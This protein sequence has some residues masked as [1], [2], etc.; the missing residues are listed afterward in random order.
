MQMPEYATKNFP[1]VTNDNDLLLGDGYIF[2]GERSGTFDETELE[3]GGCLNGTATYTVSSEKVELSAGSPEMLIRVEPKSIRIELQVNYIEHSL[4]YFDYR[5]GMGVLSTSNGVITTVT[6]EEV[7]LY[8]SYWHRLQGYNLFASPA[9]T[10]ESV[11]GYPVIYQTPRDYMIHSLCGLIKR[12]STGTIANY[13]EVAVSYQ[14]NKPTTE[15]ISLGSHATLGQFPIKFVVPMP[16]Q[17]RMTARLWK[18]V[19]IESGS[20]NFESGNWTE[21]QVTYVAVADRTQNPEALL[22][23]IEKEIEVYY[24][25]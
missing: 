24:T 17:R 20:M 14:W 9:P 18:A 21:N 22:G 6:G 5:Y 11:D 8:G 1:V 12:I 15:T 13:A 16:D 4:K 3:M 25:P 10:V 2:L 7:E 19:P 23:T